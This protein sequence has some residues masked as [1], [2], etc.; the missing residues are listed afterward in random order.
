MAPCSLKILNTIVVLLL[1]YL[2]S[3]SQ[4]FIK[5]GG[6]ENYKY[7]PKELSEL[8]KTVVSVSSPTDGTTDLFSTC[9]TG[10]VAVPKNFKGEQEPFEGES[11]AGLYLMAPNDYR[12]YIQF[13]FK[14]TLKK[15]AYYDFEFF[16][17]LAESSEVY[18]Q[19]LQALM[20]KE[21]IQSPTQKNLSVGRIRLDPKQEFIFLKLQPK[22]LLKNQ[23]DW[24]KV[25]G[26]FKSLGFEKR[27][28]IG[29]FANNKNTKFY[30][31]KKGEVAKHK[32]YAYYYVDDAKINMSDVQDDYEYGESYIL[33]SVNFALDDYS[34][35]EESRNRLKLVYDQ[36]QKLPN[37]KVTINGHTDD[38]GSKQHNDFLSSRRAK[39]VANHLVSLGFPKDRIIWKG[40]GNRLPLIPETSETAR[41]A[42]RRVDFTV[43][44][45][46]DE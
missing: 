7:C 33:R 14:Q 8:A 6:F 18:V 37:I 34:L 27:I 38:Q 5:N 12:E 10:K 42:N 26:T 39:A 23:K 21:P 15:G 1:F 41:R 17:S 45:F 22:G 19:W 29:N 31:V 11:Y 44:D 43:T 46:A 30:S 36:L 4:N 3:F 25:T 9:S 20:V 28:L 24:I 16:L 13:E 40:H 32:Q 35:D 2:T